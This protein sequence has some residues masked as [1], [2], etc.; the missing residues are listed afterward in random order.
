MSAD[1]ALAEPAGAE[2][3]FETVLLLDGRPVFFEE[4]VERFA[5]GC[6]ALGL[7]RAPDADRLRAAIGG[8]GDAG[9]C[10]RGVLRWSAWR[11]TDGTE[12][13][14]LRREAA[15]PSMLKAEWRVDVAPGRLPAAGPLNRWKHL[16]RD[17]WREAL[18]WARAAGADEAVVLDERGRVVEGAISNLFCV[19]G[20]GV[21]TPS[22]EY[23]ALP[24]IVREK[25]VKM[26]REAGMA[27][28]ERELRV[29]ELSRAEEAFA[30]NSLIGIRPVVGVGARSLAGPG[31]VTRELMLRWRSRYGW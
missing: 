9:S 13:W 3:V 28:E 8:A 1:A 4:H 18:V 2:G 31:A 14:S 29:E 7:K 20:G 16:G 10:E 22:L 23:G 25:V 21:V 11:A 17:A 12:G 27:L 24:G 5:G 6:A 26:A 30:T 15:R 19:V